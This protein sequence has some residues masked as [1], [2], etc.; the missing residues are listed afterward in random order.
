MTPMEAIES[1]YETLV[2]HY[3]EGDQ[4]EVRAAAKLLL[5]ALDKMRLHGGPN[6]RQLVM[7]YV[8]T[9]SDD[10]ER[11][12]QILEKNRTPKPPQIN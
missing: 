9:A 8:D 7:E 6:W 11:F 10:P 12:D 5:V 4:R 2:G 3:G 1:L